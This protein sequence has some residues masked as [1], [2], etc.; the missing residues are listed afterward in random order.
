MLRKLL[1]LLSIPII[2]LIVAVS[3]N[4]YLNN[5][6]VSGYV[7]YAKTEQLR[8]D[9]EALDY[10]S[11]SNVCSG[12]TAV[13]RNEIADLCN[14]HDEM[15]IL[16]YASIATAVLAIVSL[17]S[18]SIIGIISRVHRIMLV[19]CFRIGIYVFLLIGILL[20]LAE[21]ALAIAAIY[22]GEGALI[23]R[24]HIGLIIAIGIAVALG[25]LRIIVPA[26][27]TVKRAR[28][29]VF[30]KVLSK[31]KYPLL[32]KMVADA[33]DKLKS[34]HPTNIIAG[35]GEQYFVTEA[36]VT[37]LDGTMK[38][39]T[40]YI[41]LPLMHQL[42]VDELSSIVGHE[43][44]HFRG[45][46]TI[47]SRH[48]YPVY[49]GTS[50][51]LTNLFSGLSSDGGFIYLPVL[52]LL[53][54]FIEVFSKI[55]SKFSRKRELLADKAGA[56]LTSNETFGKAL[57]KIYAYTG[58]WDLVEKQMIKAIGEN[59]TLINTSAYYSLL[60]DV[61][62]KE[63]FINAISEKH[64]EHPTDSHPSLDTRLSN[65]GFKQT[66]FNDIVKSPVT[67]CS[68]ELIQDY[69]QLEEELSEYEH[70]RL[71]R[72]GAAKLPDDAAASEQN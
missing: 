25:V 49:R 24:I 36:D 19:V 55:E 67:N 43:L 33:T 22:Y 58:L 8:T 13:A 6:W 44:G 10:V 66:D 2:A 16:M 14:Y 11:L 4:Y 48:F 31:D 7:E 52:S 26:L 20:L 21:G 35:L 39:R 47:Y 40:L 41:S 29:I 38:G 12:N 64:I 32:W 62:D 45:K 70:V 18:I 37:C 68:I 71:I 65:L 23:N 27:G 72:I 50:D 28:T 34:L 30:G 61:V 60:L 46:D 15:N 3:I 5:K 17:F 69:K 9:K 51:A 57:T 63:T 42:S 59:K 1:F 53:L 54:H 56:E